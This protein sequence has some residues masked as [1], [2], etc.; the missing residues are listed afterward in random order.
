MDDLKVFG[1]Y[2]MIEQGAEDSL[3]CS[4]ERL[5]QETTDQEN[6]YC[7]NDILQK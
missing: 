6:G 4:A 2:K 5:G 1:D 7:H 3:S